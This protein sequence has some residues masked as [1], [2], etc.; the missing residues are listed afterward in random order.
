MA[1]ICVSEQMLAAIDR[2]ADFSAAFREE[3]E[4]DGLRMEAL[5]CEPDVREMPAYKRAAARVPT[6]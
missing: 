2:M 4:A 6:D 5:L 1:R 3:L